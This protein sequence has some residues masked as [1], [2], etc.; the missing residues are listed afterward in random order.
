MK[1][2]LIKIS[3]F[4]VITV[5]AVLLGACSS[6]H[7]S[8]TAGNQPTREAVKTHIMQLNQELADAYVAADTNRLDQLLSQGHIHNNIF[9]SSMDKNT[10]LKDIQSGELK[11][12][13]YDIPQMD[14]KVIDDNVCLTTGIIRAQVNRGGQDIE[15]RFR[16][17]RIFVNENGEWK[18]ALFHNTVIQPQPTKMIVEKQETA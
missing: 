5:C 9:G 17:T 6:T 10:F 4:A 2:P 7:N 1:T 15:G 14:V 12:I 13:S 11:F 8:N 16:F 18:V 3:A